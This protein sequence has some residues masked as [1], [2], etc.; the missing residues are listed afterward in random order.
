MNP[1]IIK[2]IS[3]KS[4]RSLLRV[5]LSAT[6]ACKYGVGSGRGRHV[7]DNAGLS[8]SKCI[9]GKRLTCKIVKQPKSHRSKHHIPYL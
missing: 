7:V 8:L 1:N 4:Y 2:R 3:S 5:A 6:R 9:D